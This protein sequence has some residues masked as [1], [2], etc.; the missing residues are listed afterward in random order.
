M[1]EHICL[2]ASVT[3]DKSTP[4]QVYLKA[5]V[6]VDA[7]AGTSLKGSHWNKFTLKWPMSKAGT[8]TPL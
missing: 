1:R 3:G 8:D 4:V 7:E 2:K 5:S 6:A